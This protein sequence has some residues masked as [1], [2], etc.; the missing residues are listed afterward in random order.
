MNVVCRNLCS[1][2]AVCLLVGL[3][4]CSSSGVGRL[5]AS[6]RL[7]EV[8]NG[9]SVFLVSINGKE[10]EHRST[11]GSLE[12]FQ[13]KERNTLRLR[14]T[15]GRGTFISTG[16]DHYYHVDN[17]GKVTYLGSLKS[18]WYEDERP[19]SYELSGFR[20]IPMKGKPGLAP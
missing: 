19:V 2:S 10:F 8:I 9:D 5:N 1:A 4:G 6:F 11:S 14:V 16:I 17:E 13:N 20:A 18:S 15:S 12:L 3:V 7:A